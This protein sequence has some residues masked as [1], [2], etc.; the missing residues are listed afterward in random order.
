MR[1][2][3]CVSVENVSSFLSRKCIIAIINERERERER[4]REKEGGISSVIIRKG[5]AQ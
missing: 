1:S 4:E 5:T 2:I 3:D